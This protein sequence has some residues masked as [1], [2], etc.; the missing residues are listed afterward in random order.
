MCV[1]IWRLSG[2]YSKYDDDKLCNIFGAQCVLL[3]VLVRCVYIF[4]ALV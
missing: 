2:A 3:D 1:A 4:G